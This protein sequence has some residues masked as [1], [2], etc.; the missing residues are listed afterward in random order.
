MHIN[1]CRQTLAVSFSGF[2]FV[3]FIQKWGASKPEWGPSGLWVVEGLQNHLGWSCRGNHK[4]EWTFSKSIEQANFEF[5]NLVW[6]VN[7]VTNVQVALGR[8]NVPHPWK[9][10]TALCPRLLWKV[11]PLKA[12]SWSTQCT[13]V[14]SGLGLLKNTLCPWE[15]FSGKK[16]IGIFADQSRRTRAL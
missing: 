1:L 9:E 15:P 7:D 6:P 14:V 8:K 10:G 2:C 4:W 3:L 5:G 12:V 13:S 16:I 11:G